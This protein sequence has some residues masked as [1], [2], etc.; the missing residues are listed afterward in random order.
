MG[1]FELNATGFIDATLR[2]PV[3]MTAAAA[4]PPR[5]PPTNFP[6]GVASEGSDA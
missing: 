2:N 1:R 4:A 3:L 6:P 5:D